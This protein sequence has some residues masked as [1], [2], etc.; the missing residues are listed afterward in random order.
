MGRMRLISWNVN[1]RKGIAEAQA[2]ALGQREPDIVALQEIRA[3]TV[4]AWEKQLRLCGLEHFRSTHEF[5]ED[6]HNFVAAASRWPLR[7]SGADI[8]VPMRELV[9]ALEVETEPFGTVELIATH[10]P[11]GSSYGEKKVRH[12]EALRRHLEQPSD[13]PRILCGD[14]NS[15]RREFRDER[16]VVTWAQTEDGRLRKSRGQRWDDAERSV[17][18]GLQS[19]GFVDTFRKLHPGDFSQG[20]WKPRGPSGI[21]RRFDHVFADRSLRATGC[22]F[23]HAWR[24]DRP[25]LSDH[26]A[27]E[28][29]F[30]SPTA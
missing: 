14:F 15:P 16:G 21:E 27:I 6:R 26:S 10:V 12:F 11:N 9:L 5:V 30:S 19:L 24:T 18:A 25:S 22:S 13:W 4:D 1:A 20:T 3:G 29:E 17:I 28:V 8:D 7:L 23:I 2:S